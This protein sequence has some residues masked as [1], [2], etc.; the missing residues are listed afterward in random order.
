MIR[1]EI[2]R[3]DFTAAE[4]EALGLIGRLPAAVL[5]GTRSERAS[6]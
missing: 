2:A 5:L 1:C 3:W 4:R 6:F